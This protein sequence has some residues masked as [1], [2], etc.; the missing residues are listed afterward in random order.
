MRKIC[1]ILLVICILGSVFPAFSF[2]EEVSVTSQ[3]TFWNWAAQ[4]S[5]DGLLSAL[6]SYSKEDVC[7]VSE[8][9]HHHATYPAKTSGGKYVCDFCGESFEG[10]VFD[11]QQSY[12]D[13]VSSMPATGYNSSGKI[14]WNTWDS[15]TGSGGFWWTGSGFEKFDSLPCRFE[16]KDYNRYLSASLAPSGKGIYVEYQKLFRFA[17]IF[18][19]KLSYPVTGSYRRISSHQMDISVISPSSGSAVNFSFDY[20]EET[21]LTYRNF[22]DSFTLNSG[23]GVSRSTFDSV[24]SP[25]DPPFAAYYFYFPIYEIV[26]N[27]IGNTTISTTYAPTTRPTTITGGNYGI[28]GDN[29]QITKIEDNSTIIN[30]TN[31]TYYNP[32]TGQTVPITDWSYNYEDRSYTVTTDSGNTST[33]TYGD[34]N[35]SIVENNVV[36]GGD[37]VTNNYTIYYITNNVGGGGDN[38]E[39]PD[40]PNSGSSSGGSSSGSDTP[41]CTHEWGEAT[42]V[43]ATC[44]IPGSVSATCTKC[45]E[46]KKETIPALGHDWQVK[47][48]VTTEYDDSGQLVQQG[49][50]IFECSRCHEQYKSED[51]KVPPGGGSGTDPGGDDGKETIWQKLGKLIG[52]I[53]SGALGLIDAALGKVLDALIALVEMLAEKLSTVVE[54]ILSLFDELPKIFGGFLDFLAAVFPFLPPELMLLLTFGVV[55]IVVIGIIKALRR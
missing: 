50:T 55:A 46:S 9:T 25:H 48:T 37:T 32:A 3:D 28:V 29:G 10:S 24:T 6:I 12:T 19:T 53:G 15:F 16:Q 35:I 14:I 2:A 13:Q 40:D 20:P 42:T 7:T 44:T 21:S 52:A 34:E 39:N 33:I 47:Q 23:V 11:Y 22:G 41:S 31:N 49:Y 26:P 8:D 17:E 38:P 18:S 30:E 43:A 51:G 54:T 5:G 45:G 36:E 1:S 27:T 4:N